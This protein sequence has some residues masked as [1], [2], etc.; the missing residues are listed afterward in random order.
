VW[1]GC[2]GAGLESVMFIFGIFILIFAI[3]ALLLVPSVYMN[4][5]NSFI[6]DDLSGYLLGWRMLGLVRVIIGVAISMVG[7]EAL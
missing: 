5:A 4:L 3:P 6:P 7:F 2:T 1:S